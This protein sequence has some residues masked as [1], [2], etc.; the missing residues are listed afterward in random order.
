[1]KAKEYYAKYGELLMNPETEKEALTNLF[2]DF[3]DEARSLMKQ[4]KISN[5][6]ATLAI[7]DEL[8]KKWNALCEMFPTPT[9]VRNAYQAYWYKELGI[10]K[11]RADMIRKGRMF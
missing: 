5:D 2:I 1:M 8:N 9:L 11:E 3:V 4:R 10:T 6:K 7:I